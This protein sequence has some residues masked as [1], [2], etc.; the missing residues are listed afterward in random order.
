MSFVDLENPK[1]RAL[2][3]RLSAK[4]LRDPSLVRGGQRLR[5]FA[6][7]RKTTR[8]VVAP[9][10]ALIVM[11]D[12]KLTEAEL[13]GEE[14]EHGAHEHAGSGAP[15][16]VDAHVEVSIPEG[17]LF[18]DGGS[19]AV[20]DLF[21]EEGK[22]L[23]GD[24]IEVDV[25]PIGDIRPSGPITLAAP[26]FHQTFA[27]LRDRVRPAPAGAS[28]GHRRLQGSGSIGVYLRDTKGRVFVLSA[29][30]V[31]ALERGNVLGA[32][33]GAAGLSLAALGDRVIQPGLDVAFRP[34][35]ELGELCGWIDLNYLDGRGNERAPNYADVAIAE[36]DP[37]A[38]TTMVPYLQSSG[39]AA[40][41][42][43]ITQTLSEGAFVKK[44]GQATGLTYGRILHVGVPVRLNYTSR[45]AVFENQCITTHMSVNGD[46]GS[47]VLG[48]T[49]NEVFGTLFAG[50]N[51]VSIFTPMRQVLQLL[52]RDL[53]VDVT[54][55][56]LPS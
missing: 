28:L 8:G 29:N 35:H 50:S 32:V 12:R 23:G 25:V 24:T 5:A 34:E 27:T 1:I 6:V 51:D 16:E 56:H 17:G 42:G 48:A 44:V 52:K 4:L 13:H 53:G 14:G 3:L 43:P 7:G 31:I 26:Q 21:G 15:H 20:V 10:L 54:L 37:A 45:W 39:A 36:V 22:R 30:H 55:L 46:S 38:A 33:I 19:K 9:G 40:V 41:P 49:S 11:V 2:A 47:M 18:F